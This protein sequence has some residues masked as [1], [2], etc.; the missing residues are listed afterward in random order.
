MTDS[1]Y[2]QSGPWQRFT[3]YFSGRSVRYFAGLICAVLCFLILLLPSP[4]VIET[5]GPTQD[6]LASVDGKP[7]IAISD[8]TTHKSKGK[9]LL[10]TVNAQGVPGSPANGVQTLIAWFDPQQQVMPSEAV[11]PVGQSA[12]D[13]K[14][15]SAKEMT[16]SQD[17]ATTASLAFARK[18]KIAGADSAKVKMHV[19]DIGGPSAG[20]MYALG[21]I[22]KLTTQDETGGK[23]I[24]GTGTIDDNGK[25]GKIGG[26]QL[27]ML[28]A[29][30]DGVTYFL[31][32]A[33]NCSEVVGHVPSG[34]RD[35]KVSTLDEAYRAL[36]AIGQNK[37]E[38]L[39][40]CTA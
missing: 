15:T 39:P 34:L 35:V 36:V 25:I 7:V 9:L 18:H 33:D 30:R 21:V 22:D 8:A 29:K 19:E 24:A 16:G 31:A 11:F 17:S 2:G 14:K 12:G 23:T 37:A 1:R 32:P 3:H 40:H 13:Y 38:D 26:I 28:G 5:P 4:Y 10:L 20:L 27:K 6:V